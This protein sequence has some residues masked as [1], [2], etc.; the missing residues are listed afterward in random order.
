MN[1]QADAAS[2]T[3]GFRVWQMALAIVAVGLIL[4]LGLGALPGPPADQHA[5]ADLPPEQ[6]PA[7]TDPVETADAPT[8]AVDLS[9]VEVLPLDLQGEVPGPL[10]TAILQRYMPHTT[11]DHADALRDTL[12]PS[13]D[14]RMIVIIPEDD[15]PVF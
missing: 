5:E 4:R 9:I 13:E 8:P 6:Q 3:C 2:T 10:L 1:Q 12:P 7:E 11:A 15:K 14:P